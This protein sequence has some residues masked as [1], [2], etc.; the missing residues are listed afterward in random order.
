MRLKQCN[1]FSKVLMLGLAALLLTG[2]DMALMNPKGQIGM[3]QKSLI[4]TATLLMLIVVVPVIIM[5]FLFAWKYRESNKEAKYTPNWA[6]SNKIEMVVWGIPCVIILVLGTLTWKSTHAL[7]PRQT[8]PSEA[9]T[10]TI[11]EVSMDWKWLFIY[12]DLGIASVNELSF[13]ENV[14][15]K[16][17]I[18]S[19]TVM[20]SFFI[21]RLGSQIYAMGGMQNILHLVANE[22]G[23]YPG[24]SANYSGKGF[25]GMKFNAIVT[26]QEDF[27]KWVEKVKQSPNQLQWEDYNQLAKPSEN[28]PVEYFSVVKSGLYLDII[29]KYMKMD[30][31]KHSH[32]SGGEE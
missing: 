9:Q 25:S 6:H 2:C 13:P 30:T 4:I 10:I 28:N 3:E 22:K 29:N 21:P 17:K 18:T 8:I 12:P 32:H 27:D 26:S 23:V 16:F 20:N 5:T 19:D 1:K 24:M 15:V 31:S 7:D 14:P 11:E